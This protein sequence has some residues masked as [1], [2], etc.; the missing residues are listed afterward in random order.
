VS[1]YARPTGPARDR[2]PLTHSGPAAAAGRGATPSYLREETR[3]KWQQR[4]QEDIAAGRLELR[5]PD[6]TRVWRPAEADW[7]TAVVLVSE[8]QRWL[9][10]RRPGWTMEAEREP[11]ATEPHDPALAQR[12]EQDFLA[13]FRSVELKKKIERL[14]AM[15]VDKPSEEESR[16]RQLRALHAELRQIL[17]TEPEQTDSG[18]APKK[19][20]ARATQTRQANREAWLKVLGEFVDEIKRLKDAED[21]SWPCLRSK[22]RYSLCIPC[23]KAEFQKEFARR[24]PQFKKSPAA[25][26]LADELPAFGVRLK[27]GRMS[28]RLNPLAKLLAA[29]KEG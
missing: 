15:R 13:G 26:T 6:S 16:D 19:R 24:Y 14:E 7:Q 25:D 8:L 23:G 29:H 22:K 3:G 4:I 20:T 1:G 21:L 17:S 28:R 12:Q 5:T 9:Q 2:L 18:Q 10:D 11:K 27:Q